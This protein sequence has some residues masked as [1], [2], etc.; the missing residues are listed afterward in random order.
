MID[1]VIIYVV[2]GLG[3]IVYAVNKMDHDGFFNWRIPSE[4]PPRSDSSSDSNS[5]D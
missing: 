1:L 4:P 2:V 5:I 3:L